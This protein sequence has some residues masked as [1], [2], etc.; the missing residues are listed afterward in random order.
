[1]CTQG[2]I[3]IWWP[4]IHQDGG[5]NRCRWPL[6]FL[7]KLTWW[8][9]LRRKNNN[10]GKKTPPG[11]SRK[12]KTSLC[13]LTILCPERVGAESH[14]SGNFW[15]R[16][17]NNVK[18]FIIVLCHVLQISLP[19]PSSTAECAVPPRYRSQWDCQAGGWAMARA[20][21]KWEICLLWARY[22]LQHIGCRSLGSPL[23]L[24]IYPAP[25]LCP[26]PS[27]ATSTILQWKPP[28][29]QYPSWCLEETE[30][31]TQ[32]ARCGP[33]NSKRKKAVFI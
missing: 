21:W 23:L 33:V 11:L 3:Y 27:L 24:A 4:T 5:D 13:S 9:I 1:M 32:D 17:H 29:T 22:G 15:L 2:L 16:L 25:Y 10:K 6:L 19:L 30:R 14:L 20:S 26:S 8:A 12:K 7:E 31:A 28:P 18:K